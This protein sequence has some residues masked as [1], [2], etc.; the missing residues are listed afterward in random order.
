MYRMIDAPHHAD[1]NVGWDTVPE[2]VR[3]TELRIPDYIEITY[4]WAYV[5]PWAVRLLDRTWL[6]NLYLFSWYRRLVDMTL[7]EFETLQGSFLQISCCYGDLTLRLYERISKDGGSLDV[8]DILPIQ[9]E[10]LKHKLPFGVPVGLYHMDAAGLTFSDASYDNVLLFFL[11]HEEPQEYRV[12]T[13]REALRVLKPSGR[14]ILVDYG[15]PHR[16]HPVRLLMPLLNW[17]EP[18]AR[19]LRRQPLTNVLPNEMANHSWRT[20]SLFGGL[21]QIIIGTS[22]DRSVY[23]G[24]V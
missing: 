19:E 2:T 15:V 12:K 9:L 13:L 11:L 14:I 4:W 20:L 10:N 8:V 6:V 22:K 23:I 5:R 17:L 18:T 3:S 1:A 16:S 24:S 21:Y 7:Q